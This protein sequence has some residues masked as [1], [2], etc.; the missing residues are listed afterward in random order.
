[1]P[2]VKL[3][4]VLSFSSEDV[5]HPADNLLRG[6]ALRKWRCAAG[7]TDRQ[8]SVILKLERL[9]SL[10][11]IDIGNDGSAFIEVL[12]G[13]EG[14]ADFQVLLVASS[15][16]TPI[17]SRNGT[18]LHRV[19]MFGP[20][21]LNKTVA[22]QKWDRVKVICTQPF[23]R[24]TQ[25]GLSFITI[26][27]PD[28]TGESQA[29]PH[30]PKVTKLGSFT[31]RD[32]D[33]NDPISVGSVFAKHKD[34]QPPVPLSGAAAIRAASVAAAAASNSSPTTQGIKKTDSTQPH[35]T[36]HKR[37]ADDSPQHH[38]SYQLNK[39]FSA[40]ESSRER[41]TD[42]RGKDNNSNS[43]QE[44]KADLER[45]T[46][47]RGEKRDKNERER[48]RGEGSIN[49]GNKERKRGGG[50][51]AEGNTKREGSMNEKET[52]KG[53]G[54]GG[55][56]STNETK[57]KKAIKSRPF[58]DL[59]DGVVFVLSGYQNPQR[60]NLRDAMMDMGAIYKSDWGPTC[61]HLVCAFKNTPKY[62]QVQL[63]KG[64][65]ISGSWVTQCHK[66]K[67]RYPCKRF[68][69]DARS[70]GDKEEEEEVWAEELL[71]KSSKSP[72]QHT[73]SSKS[74]V[75]RVVPRSLLPTSWCC[76]RLSP[77]LFADLPR[78]KFCFTPSFTM[79]P[80]RPSTSVADGSAPKRSRKTLT[81][82]QKLQVLERIDK[83]QKTS[84][85]VDALKL[86]ESTVRTIRSNAEKIR[87]SAKV[88]TPL[89]GSKSSYSRPVEIQRME[90]MLATWI[91]HQNKTNVP[92]SYNL[93]QAKARSIYDNL[94]VEE[95]KQFTASSGWFANFR[96]RFGFHNLKM[97]G[98]T[99]SADT[100][101]AEEY[102][103]IL[104]GIIEEGEYSSKQVF[105]LDETGLYW[106]K[107]PNRT[108]I[109]KEEATAPGF[110]AAKDRLT[111]LLGANAEGDCKLNPMLIYHSQNP[112]ALKGYDKAFL[113][114]YWY[115]N[116]KGWMTGAVFGDYF[117]NKLH[118]ELEVYC[119]QEGLPFKILL[120]W[121]EVPR[122]CLNGVWKKLCPQFVH[123][124]KGFSINE[125][126]AKA[127]GK[128]L[129]LAQQLG[130]S[131][132]G[133]EDI[134][135]LL[136]SHQNELSNEDLL[137]IE[138]ERVE[139]L[140]EAEAA[141]A[142]AVPYEQPLRTLTATNL[143]ECLEL[144]RQA[145][146]II[147]EN[148][149][150]IERSSKVSREVMNKVACYQLMLKEKQKKKKQ[151]S[152]LSFFQRRMDVKEEEKEDVYGDE[153][154]MSDNEDTD[155]EIERAKSRKPNNT[156]TTAHTNERTP[157]GGGGGGDSS[158]KT[159]ERETVNRETTVK[160]KEE[161]TVNRETA[162]KKKEEQT[163]NRETTVRRK[164]TT[165]SVNGGGLTTPK[166]G[167]DFTD[168]EVYDD[169]TDVDE[170]NGEHL[171]LPDTSS[172]PLP[173]LG[174]YFSGK[175]FLLYGNMGD[176]QRRLLHRYIT[177]FLGE[178]ENYMSDKVHYVISEDAWDRNFEEA[179]NE[180]PSLQFVR[181]LW[182]WRCCDKQRLLPHQP[183]LIVP[184]E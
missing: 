113:P 62:Q 59:M 35:A 173:S 163:V 43:K 4:E 115:A 63:S 29:S 118:R 37:K 3:T 13:R 32:D 166:N 61:T 131:E 142:S 103:A 156:P 130:F 161:Q 121:D 138:S 160:R 68:D 84:A 90:K 60:S 30:T 24:N 152:I 42:E 19:R 132:V 123:D 94:E 26:R 100:K 155:D 86:S 77:A 180:H 79:A 174:D 117:K 65:I 72:Q 147:E 164:D 73:P 89:T 34:K 7:T 97:V 111:L 46:S 16:M 47:D 74:S 50:A 124:F 36:A 21:K 182:V 137:D 108:Y 95:K 66:D 55:E 96:R 56:G 6:D 109:S 87:A 80:K 181:P 44:R 78:G 38:H 149:P 28:K 67:K 167:S 141:A 64:R 10:S 52:R 81:L 159:G 25:Y 119:K 183:Y 162:V 18:D 126:L 99:A 15:F 23:N 93:I 107:L 91:D 133:E 22:E 82:E 170:E 51:A 5:N 114:C 176:D 83:G 165:T 151:P 14:V 105:N 129:R 2:P 110:K 145:M 144:M 120:S 106:K 168:D 49:E 102:P 179:L 41:K 40:D 54:G 153:T 17:E 70:Q 157:G 148:D 175:H 39:K 104:K 45:K 8:S 11:S 171:D 27:V 112:R 92:V 134:D 178:V 127:N 98:E 169:D 31:L 33:D 146:M 116:L 128:S 139:Q 20:D 184:R 85:I 48:K 154:D 1:M 125:N 9:T 177:A 88:G 150:N 143:S 75:D 57:N 12:V 53:G 69:L 140:E 58:C 135:E 158:R 101:A 136:Q 76:E 122:S 71:P 172:L